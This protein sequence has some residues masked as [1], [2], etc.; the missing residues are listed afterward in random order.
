MAKIKQ[1][2]GANVGLDIAEELA[3]FLRLLETFPK[4]SVRQILTDPEKAPLPKKIGKSGAGFD[5]AE[6]SAFISLVI[7][8]TGESD[9]SGK[10]KVLPPIE[11]E[12][13]IKYLIRL[14]NASL[15]VAG[16]KRI[17]DKHPD[18]HKELGEP[19]EKGKIGPD[20]YAKGIREFIGKY[21]EI[22]Q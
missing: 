4:E 18:I 3:A 5:E 13:F 22:F 16:V 20:K 2:I 12:N 10:G 14:E 9:S 8:S 6:A 15:A 17:I 7:S 19:D 21:G 1:G 11:W